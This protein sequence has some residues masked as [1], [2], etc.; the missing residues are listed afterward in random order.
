MFKYIN[1]NISYKILGTKMLSECL[2]LDRYVGKINK[3]WDSKMLYW[4]KLQL[5]IYIYIYRER[6]RERG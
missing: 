3:L 4:L 5:Y 2:N 6:E 1:C